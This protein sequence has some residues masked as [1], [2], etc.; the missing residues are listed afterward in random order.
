[1]Q[2]PKVCTITSKTKINVF[3]N[4]FFTPGLLHGPSN[5]KNSPKTLILA[6][7]ANS[8][9]SRKIGLFPTF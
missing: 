7:E 3:L 4:F 6:F 2:Q 5:R 8:V 9:L 1:M